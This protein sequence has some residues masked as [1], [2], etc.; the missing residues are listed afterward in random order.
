MQKV[1]FNFGLMIAALGAINVFVSCTDHVIAPVEYTVMSS[2]DESIVPDAWREKYREDAVRLALRQINAAGGPASDE[3]ELPVDL[4]RTFYDALIQVYNATMI[5]ARDSVVSIYPIHTFP[6]PELHRLIVVVDSTKPWV[7]AW[8]RG[9]RLTGNPQID[10]LLETFGLQL[11]YYYPGPG[12]PMAILRS[13]RPLNLSALAER[14]TGID[15]VNY[16]G[17]DGVVGA[18]NDIKASFYGSDWQLDYSLGWGDCPAGCTA[19]HFWRFHIYSDGRVK[20]AGSR[21]TPLSYR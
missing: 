21:G 4:V 19:R 12:S 13:T 15:G 5:P 20:Y 16:A 17:P 2:A 1:K 6:S 10:Q 9:E 14:F 8:R 18:G 7:Q 3:V 11:D